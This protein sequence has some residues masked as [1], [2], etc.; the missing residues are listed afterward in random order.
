MKHTKL[1]TVLSV[2]LCTALIAAAAFV[3]TS[4]SGNNQTTTVDATASDANG[5]FSL[6]IVDLEGNETKM[7]LA[8]GGKYLGEVLEAIGLISGE[9]GPYGMYI[10]S[11]NGITADYD[12]DGTY[13]A[14][15]INGE[16]AETGIDTTEIVPGASYMLKLEQG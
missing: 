5:Q 9:E 16:Y 15:Y 3:F 14:L 8:G 6:T 12:T 10:T 7:E 13:W 2:I 1:R 11:V 4:C